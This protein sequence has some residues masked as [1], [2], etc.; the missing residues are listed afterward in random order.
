MLLFTRVIVSPLIITMETNRIYHHVAEGARE[1]CKCTWFAILDEACQVVDVANHGH[2]CCFPVPV[3]SDD[4]LF[5]SYHFTI[6][7]R[8]PISLNQNYF[9]QFYAPGLKGPPGH[10]VIG[11]SVCPFDCPSVRPSVCPYIHTAYKQSAIFKVWWWYNNQTD[12]KFIY[13]FLTLHWHLM[14]LGVG[15]RL[16]VGLRDFCHSLTSLPP[17]ASV[18]HKHMSNLDRKWRQLGL[19]LT[20]HLCMVYDVTEAKLSLLG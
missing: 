4:W 9:K 16:N 5:F 8:K 15:R 10:L 3:Q 11:L 19:I 13:G 2:K 1:P 14:P 17:G 18:F 7:M 6:F 20:S 12:C